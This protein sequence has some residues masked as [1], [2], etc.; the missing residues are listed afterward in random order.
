MSI[1]VTTF[2][3]LDDK[4]KFFD[5]LASIST[6]DPANDNMWDTDWSNKPNT[7]PYLL[8]K[9]NKFTG[10]NG[11]FHIALDGEKI[12]ACG[13]VQIAH[14]C[15]KIA[16][17]GVRTWILPE[18]RNKMIIGRQILPANKAWATKQGCKQVAL[19]FNEYNKSLLRLWTRIR[20]GES[21]DRISKRTND[22]MFFNGVNELKFP[23]YIQYT[24]QWVV[25]EQLDPDWNFNWQAFK[26]NI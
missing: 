10:L 2:N 18:Y 24:P 14:F 15:N 23:V 17:C 9:T 11:E 22:M 6:D 12:V 25:Y 26:V 3:K 21:S 4:Q 19:S 13:G 16:L 5:F 20:I 8:T 1:R 7:L